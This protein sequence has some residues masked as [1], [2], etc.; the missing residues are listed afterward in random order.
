MGPIL[1]RRPANGRFRVNFDELGCDGIYKRQ[2][3]AG[4]SRNQP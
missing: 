1:W 3:F 4:K 2:S